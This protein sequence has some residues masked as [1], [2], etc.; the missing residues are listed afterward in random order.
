MK[1][2]LNTVRN[3]LYKEISPVDF[4][5][6]FAYL[7]S[8][9]ER[10]K[11]RFGPHDFSLHGIHEFYADR[12]NTGYILRNMED[13]HII[14]YGVVRQGYVGGDFE[15]YLSYGTGPDSYYDCTLAPSVADAWQ[16]K[17]IGD[18]LMH[19][20]LNE[21]HRKQFRRIVLWGG[22]QSTNTHAVN[23]YEKHHFRKIADFTHNGNNHDMIYWLPDE[24][25]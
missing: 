6:L 21:V 24:I 4:S 9:S 23:F 22:V 5:P 2:G 10:T 13:H 25:Q 14:A 18:L 15:R 17:G 19:F 8:F 16:R 3:I 11:L 1:F 7:N 20:I 12:K